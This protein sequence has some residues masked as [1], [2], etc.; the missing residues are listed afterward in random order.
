MKTISVLKGIA[1][2]GTVIAGLLAGASAQAGI[3]GYELNINNPVFNTESGVNNVPDIRLENTS[4]L[5]SNAQISD[6]TLTIG[7]TDFNFDFVRNESVFFNTGDALGFTRNAPDSDNDHV[8]PD[9]I[10]YDFTGFDAR[11]IFQF[12]VD[13]DPDV[14]EVVQDYRSI[15]FPQSLLTVTFT[16]GKQL[17]QVLSPRDRGLD[18]YTFAQSMEV[19]EPAT[20]ALFGGFALAGAALRRR[21]Q[22]QR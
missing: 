6:F 3:V 20:L 7:D 1:L 16:N 17:Q 2:S 8:G 21:K 19:S 18:G 22:V 10:D 5:S 9:L 4:S 15:L 12:E 13:V 11:D 14:G